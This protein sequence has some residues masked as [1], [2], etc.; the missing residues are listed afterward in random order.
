MNPRSLDPE[1]LLNLIQKRRSIRA[2]DPGRPVPED[3]VEKIIE[4]GIWAPTGTNQQELR[5]HVLTNPK[6]LK[7]FARFKKIKTS[8]CVVLIF[9]DFEN[10]YADFSPRLKYRPHK[11]PLP[12]IDTG[13]SLMNMLLMAE[14]L[15]LNSVPL[16]ISPDLYYRDTGNRTLARRLIQAACLLGHRSV[17]GIHFFT[18]FCGH[19]GINPQRYIPAGAIALGY[20]TKSVDLARAIHGKRPITRKESNYYRLDRDQ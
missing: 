18:E 17:Y 13:L 8:P 11:R 2:F 6:H 9:I 10:Y 12:F 4:A 7:E 5:F 3:L 1:L 14:A 19:I 15:G 16:N 20:G